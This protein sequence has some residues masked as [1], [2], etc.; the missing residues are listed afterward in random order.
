ME[1]KAAGH[2]TLFGTTQG[3]PL[4]VVGDMQDVCRV[5]ELPV[6]IGPG[7]G[8]ILFFRALAAQKGVKTIFTNAGSIADLDLF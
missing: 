3:I 4:A 8:K 2:N 1:I 7:L 5:V 6:V